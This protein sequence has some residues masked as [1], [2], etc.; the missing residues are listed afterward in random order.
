VPFRGNSHEGSSTGQFFLE[1]GVT[2]GKFS[3]R[4]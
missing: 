1:P 2:G 4:W 3:M